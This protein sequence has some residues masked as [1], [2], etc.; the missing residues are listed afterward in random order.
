[1][2]SRLFSGPYALRAFIVAVLLSAALGWTV[3]D[4]VQII[5]HGT[6]IVLKTRPVD[7]R[8]LFRGHY[9]RLNYDISRIARTK[10][11]S[12][13]KLKRRARVFVRLKPGEDGFWQ[14]TEVSS[15]RLTPAEGSVILNATVRS[16]SRK[17]VWLR[18]GIERYFA[19]K[20]KALG[21]EKKFR[22]RKIEVG[23]IVRVA[24]YGAAA[25]SGLQLEGKK[26]Y[27]E[28]LF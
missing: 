27:D 19:P 14:V 17:Q 28:P 13:G 8:S 4:Q 26:V 20:Q 6:E 5:R 2:I 23:V 15:A 22:D 18:Y 11:S 10:I 16:V 9:A 21:L 25:I 1:M 3:W 24:K 12:G 7:P